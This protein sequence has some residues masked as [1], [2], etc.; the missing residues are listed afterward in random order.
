MPRLEVETVQ[1][2]K[3][4]Y[5][6]GALTP[7]MSLQLSQILMGE[8]LENKRRR[9]ELSRQREGDKQTEQSQGGGALDAAGLE[10]V[11][12]THTI[13]KGLR[14]EYDNSSTLK[15]KKKKPPQST[16]AASDEK[17]SKH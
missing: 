3:A 16:S 9:V 17:Q 10:S 15:Q 1:D 12:Q 5:D 11:K 7:D 6:I 8:D 4:L 2:M 14:G 13:K